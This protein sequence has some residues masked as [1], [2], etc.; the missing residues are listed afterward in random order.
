MLVS[1]GDNCID[2]YAAP[3]GTQHV[4]GNALN[5]AANF[6]LHGL[7]A[8]YV[9]V[10]GTDDYGDLVI[11]ALEA[12]GVT[13][14]YVER[15]AGPTGITE[16]E[17]LKGD[18]RILKEEYGVSDR[19]HLTSELLGWVRAQASQLHLTVSGRAQE[20]IEGLEEVGVP[21]S[22]D[23][24]TVNGPSM[25]P[26]FARLTA[27]AQSAFV[28]VGAQMSDEEVQRLLAAIVRT[29]TRYAIATRGAAGASTL[30]K[31]RLLSVPPVLPSAAIVDTLG[32]GDAFIAGF[33]S[34]T[35]L[36]GGLEERLLRASRWSAEAC[37]QVG[38][39]K[40]RRS[41]SESAAESKP[42]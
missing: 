39:W 30:W 14:A 5:V 38:A 23:L 20:L 4:G 27:T 12:I 10:V 21:L 32:A 15:R 8:A 17:L 31:G 1:I 9:G 37:S 34:G 13:T 2:R 28:S 42:L 35:D 40:P 6:V 24:G 26:S 18:Y 22:V 29:G 3:I 41:A 25:L 7:P 16:I 19:V 11:A 36:A 33:L